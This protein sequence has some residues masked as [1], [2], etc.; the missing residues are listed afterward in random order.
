MEDAKGAA[1]ELE[2]PL[3]HLYDGL[4]RSHVQLF[5]P[6]T[7]QI[8]YLDLFAGKNDYQAADKLGDGGHKEINRT[9]LS[10]S[11]IESRLKLDVVQKQLEMIRLRNTSEAFKGDLQI[12]Q[13]GTHEIRLLWKKKMERAKLYVNLNTQQLEIEGVSRGKNFKLDL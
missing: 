10:G 1:P 13:S 3:A 7:P 12:L 11:D 6:G 8:W 9:N 5:M 4:G 2:A